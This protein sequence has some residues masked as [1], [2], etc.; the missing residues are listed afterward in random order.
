MGVTA[1]FLI[2]VDDPNFIPSLKQI[3]DMVRLLD[4]YGLSACHYPTF[5]ENK[6]FIDHM[7]CCGI[8]RT[9]CA[10]G[11]PRVELKDSEYRDAIW[12]YLH[13][14]GF[15]D[16]AARSWMSIQGYDPAIILNARGFAQH[17]IPL[18]QNPR[19]WASFY[20][21]LR[22]RGGYISR[23]SVRELRDSIYVCE[24][25][26]MYITNTPPTSYGETAPLKTRF[27]IYSE[28]AG[29]WGRDDFILDSFRMRFGS[30]LTLASRI[31]AR[32][33]VLTKV[34]HY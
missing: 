1:D 29:R 20:A 22:A 3:E 18:V 9:T 34:F 27:V 30:F 28:G 8:M 7:E 12:K 23:L 6:I 5:D 25:G 21:F 10:P 13:D 24:K 16:D 33:V 32:N 17:T 15:S 2:I 11:R 14:S 31:C 19:L 26:E 4:L